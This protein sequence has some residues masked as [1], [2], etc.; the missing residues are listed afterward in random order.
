[1]PSIRI[2]GTSAYIGW[3]AGLDLGIY[4]LEIVERFWERIQL[5]WMGWICILILPPW[6]LLSINKIPQDTYH[7]QY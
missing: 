5:S 7:T 6:S 1:M 3:L 4:V 2:S